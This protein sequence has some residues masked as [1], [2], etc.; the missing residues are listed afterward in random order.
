VVPW[1]VQA[2]VDQV[3]GLDVI[4]DTRNTSLEHNETLQQA[5]DNGGVGFNFVTIVF[6]VGDEGVGLDGPGTERHGGLDELGVGIAPDWVTV[7]GVDDEVNGDL[8]TQHV[9]DHMA[10]HADK[11]REVVLAT[12]P[13]ELDGILEV[14][15]ISQ[16]SAGVVG[17]QSPVDTVDEVG[18]QE[19]TLTPVQARDQH[20]IVDNESSEPGVLVHNR[21]G[22]LGLAVIELESNRAVAEMRC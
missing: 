4:S 17:G 16:K 11:A 9:D 2:L 21:L 20:L 10:G 15:L 22:H 3:V 5:V 13:V 7:K 19:V 6:E 8:T 14:L 18:G 12:G 1:L